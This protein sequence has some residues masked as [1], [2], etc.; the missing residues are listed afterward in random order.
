MPVLQYKGDQVEG[1]LVSTLKTLGKACTLD[2]KNISE[3]ELR[4]TL[5]ALFNILW[6]SLIIK[7]LISLIKGD[8]KDSELDR[9]SQLAIDLMMR[10]GNDIDFYKSVISPIDDMHIVGVDFVKDFAGDIIRVLGDGDPDK[11]S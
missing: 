11:I 10:T 7:L 4:N 1:L 8:R 3:Y 2:F 5:V 9:G 6:G